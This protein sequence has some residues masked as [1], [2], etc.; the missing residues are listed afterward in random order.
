MIKNNI[1]GEH[2]AQTFAVGDIVEWSRWDS[3][4]EDWQMNYGIITNLSNE[5]R[6]NR[7]VSICKVMPLNDTTQELEFF[8]LSLRLVSPTSQ[9]DYYYELKN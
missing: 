6:S 5:I 2:V 7:M 8:T 4:G 1:F 3:S 9:K